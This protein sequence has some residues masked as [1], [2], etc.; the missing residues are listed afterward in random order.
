MR[1]VGWLPF[2]PF[3][4]ENPLLGLVSFPGIHLVCIGMGVLGLL[5]FVIVYY[6][7]ATR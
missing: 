2:A 6:V 1:P 5:G 7:Y 3:A 4:D